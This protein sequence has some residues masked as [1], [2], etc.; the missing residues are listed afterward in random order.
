MIET[1]TFDPAL[2]DTTYLSAATCDP[3]MVGTSQQLFSNILGCDSLVITTTALTPN[4]TTLLSST[5]CDP[6]ATGTFTAIFPSSTL[7]DSIVIET[8]TF[9]PALLD[10]TYLSA[11]TCDPAMVGTSQ[12]LFSN[13][14]GCDS[15]VITTT[16]LAPND[17]TLL[18]STTATPMRRARLLPFSHRPHCA[19]RS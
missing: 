2:L 6:N 18:S 12:Q 13:I 19:T 5:T 8:V 3:A 10:T 11:A 14:M 16:A 15:L 1:V 4:D 9:D 17:T 7:C